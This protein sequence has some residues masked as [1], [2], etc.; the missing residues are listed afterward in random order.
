MQLRSVTITKTQAPPGPSPPPRP[1][2]CFPQWPGQPNASG[3]PTSQPGTQAST[4]S[5]LFP[6]SWGTKH[7]ASEERSAAK[8]FSQLCN[9]TNILAPLWLRRTPLFR[10]SPQGPE[11]ESLPLNTTTASSSAQCLEMPQS[12]VSASASRFQTGLARHNY[13]FPVLFAPTHITTL[14]F[15]TW[16]V[17]HCRGRS[18]NGSHH[19]HW[20]GNGPE[21][22]TSPAVGHDGPLSFPHRSEWGGAFTHI[23]KEKS[24][25][26]GTMLHGKESTCPC[27]LRETDLID[28]TWMQDRRKDHSTFRIN[29]LETT[30]ETLS[31]LKLW[32][33]MHLVGCDLHGLQKTW[34]AENLEAA[35]PY[36]CYTPFVTVNTKFLSEGFLKNCF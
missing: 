17:R 7:T 24:L 3:K 21:F 25:H 8:L 1:A 29:G 16:Q 11:I 10:R 26:L 33:G 23:G 22:S 6:S 4:S 9:A 12:W 28:E 35:E 36:T 20:G 13:L 27:S 5:T 15:S 34:V 19:S 31:I 32:L 30:T 2:S 14:T 18:R